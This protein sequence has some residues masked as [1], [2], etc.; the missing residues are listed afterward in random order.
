MGTS[1]QT[2]E[3]LQEPVAVIGLACRLPGNCNS[4]TALWEFLE[5]G[6]VARNEAPESRF[7][8]K[9]HHDDYRK[10]KT[11]RSPGGMFLENIDPQDFDAQ[12]FR[13][14]G[15]DAIAMDPQ[16]RQLLEVVY[17]CLENAGITL[18]A[19]DGK[20]IGCFVGSFAVDYA[21]MHA[22]D[23]E[24]RPPMITVGAGRAILSNR[25]SHFLN[26]KGPSMTIDTACS[27][28]L[29]SVDLACRYLNTGEINGA[30]VAASNI[31]LSPEHV[32]D[33]GSMKGVASTSGKCHTF[34]VKADGYIKAEAVNAVMLKRL[35]DAIRDG[36]PIRGIIRGSATNSD[37]RTP[38]IAS[39]SSEAQAAAIRMAYARAG[40]VDID[41]TAYVEFHGTGTQ[42]GDPI[43]V[44][45]VAS[46]F[47]ESRSPDN[48]L[49]IG[50]VK[51]NIGHSEP[52]AGISGMLKAI[53]SI[54]KGLIPRN[55]TF[56]SPNPKIDFKALN[57]RVPQ[58]TTAWPKSK[59][60][61]ASVNS[62]G[63]GGS[64]AHVIID[65]DLPPQSKKS[66]K[67]HSHTSSFSSDW[68]LLFAEERAT[69]PVTL[70]FSANDEK[71]LRAYCK[72]ICEHLSNPSVVVKLHDLAYT[73]SERRS[74]HFN[75][76]YVVTD[77]A[78]LNEGAFTFGK[79]NTDLPRI[80]FV[81]TGQ[82]AQWPQMGKGLI[83]TFP[84]AKQMI[85]RLDGALHGL[86]NP[87]NWTLLNELTEQR[88]P[89][90]LRLPEFSQPLVTA[91]Q[92]AILAVL[93]SWGVSPS[94]VVGHSSGEIAA[95]FA[96]GLL[97][98]ENAIK[99]AYLRGQAC[100]KNNDGQ[101]LGMLAAGLGSQEIQHYLSE[102]ADLVQVACLNSPSS[103]TLSGEL[104]A[105]EKIHGRPAAN[106]HEMLKQVCGPPLPGSEHVQ[107]FSSLTGKLLSQECGPDYWM[108]NMASP[109]RFDEAVREMISGR[110]GS[111]FLIEIGPS[112]ALAGPIAQIKKALGDQGSKVQYSAS[113]TRGKD[114]VKS[115]FDVSGKLFISGSP[116]AFAKVNESRDPEVGKP[117]VIIDLPNYVWNHSTKYWHENEASKDWR[118]RKFPHHDLL[119]TKILSSSWH[120]PSWK[121]TL[122]V[123]NLHWMKDHRMGED[124]VFPAAGFIAMAVEA[125]YQ[126]RQVTDPIEEK[127][128]NS[129]YQYRLR[130][131]T[132]A[133]ALVLEEKGPGVKVM[134]SLSQH[135]DSWYEFTVSSL[136]GDRWNEHSRGLIRL[137][138]AFR[139]V[140]PESALV[141]LEHTTPSRMW[142]KAMNHIGYNFGPVFQKHI[143]M[144]TRS[145][146]R[147]ARS[148]LSLSE[149]EEE[150]R[151]SRYPM[152]PVCIDGCLQT[153][154]LVMFRGHTSDIDA[155]LIPAIIDNIV[156]VPTAAKSEI[157]IAVTSSKYA[158]IGRPEASKSYLSDVSVYDPSTK[159]LLFEVSGT[160]YHELDVL[161]SQ[162]ASDVYCKLD[163]KPDISFLKEENV[164]TLSSDELEPTMKLSSTTNRV[165]QL[166]DLAAHKKPNLKVMEV[167]MLP[168]D[169]TSLWLDDGK[170]EQRSRAACQEYHFG[171]ADVTAL[172]NVQEKYGN[173]ATAKFNLID[174]T[175]P[176]K[177]VPINGSGFDFLLIKQGSISD[178]VLEIVIKNARLHLAD[179]GFL[180]LVEENVEVPH[181]NPQNGSPVK[182]PETPPTTLDSEDHIILEISTKNDGEEAVQDLHVQTQTTV[183]DDTAFQ[184]PVSGH[185]IGSGDGSEPYVP[186]TPSSGS[187]KGRYSSCP[188]SPST[189][190]SSDLQNEGLS[191]K[192]ETRSEKAILIHTEDF[193]DA[194]FDSLLEAN[195]FHRIFKVQ[196]EN[197]FISLAVTK[198]IDSAMRPSPSSKVDLVRFTEGRDTTAAVKASLEHLGWTIEEHFSPFSNLK[199]ESTVIV[200]DE[201][202]APVLTTVKD[203]QW[204]TLKELTAQDHKILW[205]TTGSQFQVSKPDNALIHGLARTMRAED[206]MLSLITLDLQSSDA[207]ETA[208][209]V[210]RVLE[211]LTNPEL[212]LLEEKEYVERAGVLHISRV[213]PDQEVT[214]IEKKDD[215]GLEVMDL[216]ESEACIRLRCE[217][218]GTL[219]SLRWSQVSTR[220]LSLEK[221]YV[222]VEIVAAG[223]NFKDLAVTMGIVPE[224]EHLLGLEGAGI[225]TRI[226][227]GVEWLQ[228]GQRVLFH[229]KG[230]FANRVQLPASKVH[231]IP[232]SMSFEDAATM[233]SVHLVT[234]YGL[235]HRADMQKNQI[236]ATVGTE[237]KRKYLMHHFKIPADHI[238]S[239][240]TADFAHQIATVTKNEGVDIILNSLIGDL[241]D[242]SWRCIADGGTMIE[243]GKKDILARNSLSME[244]FNR[245]ASYIAVDMSHKQ[246]SDRKIGQLL[247]EMMDLATK[248]HIKP[249]TP[250]TVFPFE[251][252]VSAFRF[253]RGGSHV[254]KVVISNK[255]TKGVHISARPATPEVN[256]RPDGSYLIVGGLKGLCGSLAIYLARIGAKHLTVLCRSGYSDDKS[257][258]VLAN[259]YSHG[260]AV[261]LFEGDVTSFEDVR[262]VF[263]QATVPIR[264]LIQGSMVLRDKIYTSMTAEEFHQCISCKVEGTWNIHNASLEQEQSL[265]FFTILSSISG[266]IGQKGQANYAAANVFLDSFATYR[267]GLGLPASS[268][269]LGVIHDVGYVS[270]RADLEASFDTEV[271]LP[272]NERVLHKILRHSIIL[273]QTSKS[274]KLVSSQLIT[275]LVVPQNESSGLLRQ[276]VRFGSLGFGDASASKGSSGNDGSKDIRPFFKLLNAK[277]DQSTLL[278]AVV[279]IVSKQFTSSLRLSEPMEPGKP[280]TSYGLDSLTAVEF[281]N[282]LRL[283]L[284]AEFTTLEIMGS[285]SL[286]SMCEKILAKITPKEE[287]A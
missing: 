190:L 7:N 161:G 13:I 87:P 61:R 225:I 121:K 73:L 138:K 281:R 147:K 242:A 254:G 52:A 257:Q 250:V 1:H 156:I 49:I 159:A 154:S 215:T 221:D 170:A 252:I 266:V 127:I 64:N 22:R 24:D 248:G 267:Q 105:L 50:S 203:S 18:E 238:F 224:N 92:L 38:G 173:Q 191:V 143:K 78:N 158:G 276:D 200:L 23:P 20:P 21:D 149:P 77:N 243:I 74:R 103:I 41:A 152:H 241:L 126:A 204:Q 182:R 45:G 16:Q 66:P 63:Y 284:G 135:Q 95:A 286:F 47:S 82:G 194:T 86:T 42:A 145:G 28:A 216:H 85:N 255:A 99:V 270:E 231:L 269:D 8:L 230:A 67:F 249:I 217:R 102:S 115:L 181:S 277:A 150:Y 218:I 39:P 83:E 72:T 163:W 57:L 234:I 176:Q 3:F 228:P 256:L 140:A 197:D 137:E 162:H 285:S 141:P 244:P 264:G 27:G 201:L 26:I 120:A 4:P 202:S 79:Q 171:S 278:S 90:H 58:N 185:E 206:P 114:A 124:I 36:D 106:Y 222:E 144:E 81:F 239:S 209:T 227:K 56:Q 112:G 97:S 14:S 178:T 233:P 165:T 160:Q 119:G 268:V 123:E 65:N 37:G 199:P 283:E 70:I 88:T 107:M 116:V 6:G 208:P 96:A 31:Y 214:P 34:D 260:C 261:D 62:F 129:Q 44:N 136:V 236:F 69:Q 280:L 35:D 122:K 153:A 174:L 146:V 118:F 287:A 10:P 235:L 108:G 109:V 279:D 275:G 240:R 157:G 91:L 53:L 12:F 187:S 245:N 139:K 15:V 164:L 89:E 207:K 219:D 177:E 253:L 212:G 192:S 198:S 2:S 273:Q 60:R 25:I 110:E 175:R 259:I 51:S 128:L 133:K 196:S 17:E 111:D 237:E 98:A 101:P 40:I 151:Q 113:S 104:H 220:E 186:H 172:M 210:S 229:N 258:A 5:R 93:E 251:D 84:V 48:P 125:L 134:L 168:G 183:T 247:A 46:V 75:R 274:P 9:T 29:V 282:W 263:K 179:E 232:N 148:M 117:S 80:G 166:L 155:V 59:F 226:G 43:E 142:Y 68:E 32:M 262:R 33:E 131:A 100:S 213:R 193:R 180:L 132:F 246:I 272:I 94:R 169:E 130:N 184:Y 211:R 55:P 19:V 223:L 265:D 11:M 30:I 195:A 271:L 189:A 167:N 71:S 76:A 54:E 205:V 188:G